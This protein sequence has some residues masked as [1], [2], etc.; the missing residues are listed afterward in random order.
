M[1][2]TPQ[3]NILTI[4]DEVDALY[5]D[6]DHPHGGCVARTMSAIRSASRQPHRYQKL[7]RA[8]SERTSQWLA[9]WANSL[10]VPASFSHCH[11]IR[12]ASCRI[13]SGHLMRCPNDSNVASTWSASAVPPGAFFASSPYSGSTR[14][15]TASR[16]ALTRTLD[17]KR[18]PRTLRSAV[19]GLESAASVAGSVALI[20]DRKN[21]LNMWAALRL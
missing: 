19:A 16:G 6:A 4:R 17:S 3:T 8:R 20:R 2:G 21:R 15:H 18:P 5:G 11:L 9:S 7:R 12:V 1:G 14:R 13:A 10:C